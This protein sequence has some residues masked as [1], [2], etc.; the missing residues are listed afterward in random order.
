MLSSNGYRNGFVRKAIVGAAAI[1]AA[2]AIS[3]CTSN[4]RPMHAAAVDGTGSASAKLAK[5]KFQTIPGRPGQVIRNELIFAATGGGEDRAT[6]A[7]TLQVAVTER[8]SSALV[9]ST[10]DSSQRIYELTASFRLIRGSDNKMVL[11]GASVGRAS[12]IRNSAIYSN[13][14]ALRDA[15]DRAARTVATDLRGRLETYLATQPI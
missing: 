7:Y 9:A 14:R 8:T 6:K 2:L 3:G 1:V 5:V 12:I 4:F 10:G 11:R 15:Q 13:V